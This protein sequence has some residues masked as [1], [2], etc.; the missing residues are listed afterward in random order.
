VRE[1]DAI[2]PYPGAWDERLTLTEGLPPGTLSGK[3]SGP[4]SSNGTARTTETREGHGHSTRRW[5]PRFDLTGQGEGAI[6]RILRAKLGKAELSGLFRRSGELV[7]TPRIG[8]DGYIP[9]EEGEDLGPAQVRLLNPAQLKALVSARFDV[10]QWVPGKVKGG[11]AQWSERILSNTV[12]SVAYESARLG[13]DTPNLRELVSVTHTPVLRPDGSVLDTP[14]YDRGTGLLYLPDRGLTVPPVP[15]RPTAADIKAAVLLVA[16]LVAEFPFVSEDHRANWLGLAFTPLMRPMLEPPYQLGVFTAPNPGS[17]KSLLAWMIGK[18]HGWVMRGELPREAEEMRKA[19]SSILLTTTAPVV[20]VDNVRGKVQSSVLEGLLTSAE[21]SDRLL[22]RNEEL[23]GL[24]N[25]RLWLLTSNNAAIGGDLGR[26]VLP[27]AIDP[28]RPDPHLRTGFRL[29]LKPY[30][31]ARRGE[32]LAAMLRGP[33][34][35]NLPSVVAYAA[36]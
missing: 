34:S 8:E 19:I 23:G 36:G 16:E 26:R 17:G 6:A 11:P 28:Q 29:D 20:C 25:D 2:E 18:L 3:R 22:G 24:R 31:T 9:P 1:S 35:V 14:G 5:P 12:V 30:I 7:H 15:H 27:V 33:R 13:E 10:G 4:V 21:W 32:L